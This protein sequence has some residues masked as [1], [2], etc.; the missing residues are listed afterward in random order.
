MDLNT[1]DVYALSL[2]L[3]IAYVLDLIFGEARRFHYLVGFGKIA[4]KL[5]SLLNPHKN[6][7]S[8]TFQANTKPK[9][10]VSSGI[11]VKGLLAWC[12][13]VLPFP[14]IYTLLNQQFANQLPWLA[15]VFIDAFIVYLAIGVTSLKEHAMQIYRPLKSDKLDEARRFTG[16]IVSRDTSNLDEQQMSRATV[17]SMLEN[18]HDAA[19]ASLFYYIIGGAPLVI[20]HRLANT[21]DAMWGYKTNRFQ[22]FGYASA[23][24]D[25]VL[26]FVSGKITVLLYA[27]QGLLSGRLLSSLRNAYLQGS[28]YK[29]HNGGWVMAAGATVL[30]IKLG[31][32]ATYHGKQVKSVTLGQGSHANS[33]DI[34][35]SVNLVNH[36]CLLLILFVCLVQGVIHWH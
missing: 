29:S 28:L 31:G 7:S 12:L 10:K 35:R 4:R 5:E 34:P 36:A 17:E 6:L 30:N 24:L 20:V 15:W 8:E 22:H 26:G 11:M 13:L 16:Y 18:G 9:Q 25:D 3:V 1:L 33:N 19:I 27:L 14:I 23:R 21:L 2:T 32:N